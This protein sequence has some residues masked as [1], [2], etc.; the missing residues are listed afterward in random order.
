MQ[1]LISTKSGEPLV[2]SMV[3]AK[4]FGK[5]H[6]HV[7]EAIR[8][9]ECSDKFRESNFRPTTYVS[10]QNKTLPCVEMT[11]N[12]FSFI[13]MGFKG[14]KA[15]AWREKYI[16]AFDKAVSQLSKSV[17]V[18]SSLNQAVLKMEQDKDIASM[19]GKELAK[20]RKVKDGHEKA[21]KKLVA[22]SQ[23]LLGFE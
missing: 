11:K 6:K 22:Q 23:L 21:V 16:E 5:T 9:A 10:G 19:H 13:C 14:A 7:L 12:G 3:I 15:A 17:S 8:A 4:K 20:Y 1:D 18:M 2:S